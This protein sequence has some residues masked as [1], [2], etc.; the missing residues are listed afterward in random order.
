M[1]RVI[2]IFTVRKYDYRS[3]LGFHNFHQVY[4]CEPYRSQEINDLAK[5]QTD[6]SHMTK[7]SHKSNFEISIGEY[8]F[9]CDGIYW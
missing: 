6:T 4:K 9:T 3:I 8:V 5:G 2:L 1:I 7:L